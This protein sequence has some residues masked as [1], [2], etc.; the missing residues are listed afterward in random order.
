MKQIILILSLFT[1]MA[2]TGNSTPDG[3]K[4]IIFAKNMYGQAVKLPTN[5]NQ[6]FNELYNNLKNIIKVEVKES[7]KNSDTSVTISG[8]L[9]TDDISKAK[10][11]MGAI[12]FQGA[13]NAKRVIASVEDKINKRKNHQAKPYSKNFTAR[14][15]K[16]GDNL[17]VI[18]VKFYK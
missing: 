14:Y 6:K 3:V 4:S 13:K 15:S 8:T 17:K 5:E 1:L 10:A 12:A 9:S 16:D 11:I 18:S 7:A 2:C